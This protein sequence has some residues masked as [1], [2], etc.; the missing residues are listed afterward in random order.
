MGFL[1]KLNIINEDM[2]DFIDFYNNHIGFDLHGERIGCDL[3][4]EARQAYL[5]CGMIHLDQEVA[6]L[7][8]NIR[9]PLTL[10]EETVYSSMMPDLDKYDLGW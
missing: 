5:Q 4:D 1:G 3:S 8:V 9:Y 10:G 2:S 6:R 7:T